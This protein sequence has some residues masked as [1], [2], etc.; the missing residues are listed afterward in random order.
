VTSRGGL[1]VVLAVAVLLAAAPDPGATAQ[2]ASPRARVPPK[3]AD[4]DLRAIRN[5]FRYADDVP[6]GLAVN[7]PPAPPGEDREENLEP[8]SRVRLVGLVERSDGL[9]AALAVDGEVVLLAEGG[10]A[11]GFT[12]V[13]LGDEAVV[14]QTPQ[15][16]EQTL[17]LP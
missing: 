12:V 4:Y 16:E 1:L 14:L 11:A 10:S 6:A 7:R 15:G 13:E 5:I 8:P 2:Q 9:V 17:L 3:P